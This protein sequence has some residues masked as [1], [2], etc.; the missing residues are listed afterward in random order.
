MVLRMLHETSITLGSDVTLRAVRSRER[1][2]RDTAIRDEI[3]VSQATE[4]AEV[5][6]KVIEESYAKAQELVS[7]GAPPAD[8]Q[9]WTS[10]RAVDLTC[11]AATVVG[12]YASWIDISLVVTPRTVDILYRLLQTDVAP[13]RS[14]AADTLV[15]IVSKGMKPPDKITLLRILNLTSSVGDL[16]QRSRRQP[17]AEELPDE[18]VSFREHLAKLANCVAAELARVV[19]DTSAGQEIRLEAD[20]TL[21]SHLSLILDF[22]TDEFDEVAEAVLGCIGITLTMYKRLR[23]QSGSGDT[24]P[25]GQ[26]SEHAALAILS[27]EKL[28]FLA[29][30]MNTLLVKMKFDDESE[31][32]GTHGDENG[33]DSEDEEVAKFLSLRK[34]LQQ[35]AAS[36]ATIDESLFSVP[37]LSLIIETLNACDAQLT[38]GGPPV[39]WQR[40]ELALFAVYFSG[41]VLSAGQGPVRA[42]VS[43]T[44]FVIVPAATPK[45]TRSKPP[46]G[47]YLN[48]TLNPLGE[49]VQRFYQSQISNICQGAVQMQY[50]DCAVRFTSFFAVRPDMLPD[51]LQ[52]FLDWRGIHN[53]N[54]AVRNR[55]NYL[56]LRFVKDT[57][58]QLPASYVR[59]I[60]ESMQDVLVVKASLPVVG[61]TEDPLEEA[62]KKSSA[63]D[64]QLDLFEA[65][66]VLLHLL[67]QT[68]DEQMMLLEALVKP[69]STQLQRAMQKRQADTSSLETVL[70]IHHL[71]FSLSNLAKG[72]PDISPSSSSQSAPWMQVF[73]GVTEQFLSALAA[74]D[75]SSFRVVRDA[76][77]GAFSRMVSTTGSTVLPYVPA[78][79]NLML[80]RIS[81]SELLDFMSFL[82]LITA[83]Y[84]TDVVPILDELLRPL[85]ERTFYFLN[86]DI[87]GTDDAVMRATLVRGYITFLSTLVGAGLDN[88][89]R[90]ER[91][92]GQLETVLQSFV[93][94]ASNSEPAV[95]RQ[96]VNVLVRLVNVWLEKTTPDSPKQTR[97]G[98]G[99]ST[100]GGGD[101]PNG[102]SASRTMAAQSNVLPG[103]ESFAYKTLVPLIFE[104]PG[105]PGFD[106]GDAQSQIALTELGNLAKSVYQRRGPEFVDFLLSV[107]FPSINCPPELANSFVD[108]LQKVEGKVLKRS[109]EVSRAGRCFVVQGGRH[110]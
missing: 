10:Q 37:T 66:G 95:V 55:A 77:R 52:P 106:F 49:M 28:Q 46:E 38:N 91:N 97:G 68:P 43:A 27:T 39:S 84:K 26:P 7:R 14:A 21:L 110:M 57:R 93:F 76:A 87:A 1:I 101:A 50:F 96:I 29:R 86:Q 12:D 94:Y 89:L 32:D 33:D 56:F 80:P 71:F 22:L 61:P 73:K 69:L 79:L 103:F 40:A 47:F 62:L 81:E 59:G 100:G 2:A 23:R 11:R 9:G 92:Q 65:C 24:A 107:F 19:E 108:A 85:L 3:R 35:H 51:A 44:S 31:W 60:L 5:A 15:E 83:K 8:E 90:S 13:V 34:Q 75:L 30:L 54:N 17:G 67:K 48:L 36:I 42:G 63:F 16:E 45:A 72:F 88:V 41:E 104:I 4:I 25:N 18:E 53:E 70:E 64:Y 99:G 20:Q 6:W 105:K 74:A 82:Q 58:E 78:L 102:A 109:L 98:S